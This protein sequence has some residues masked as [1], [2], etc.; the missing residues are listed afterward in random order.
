M[1]APLNVQ[2]S[3]RTLDEGPEL[4]LPTGEN[5]HLPLVPGFLDEEGFVKT[6]SM[7]EL[8]TAPKKSKKF[9]QTFGFV[10]FKVLDDEECEEGRKAMHNLFTEKFPSFE[11][12]NPS[13][14]WPTNKFGMIGQGRKGD[15]IVTQ[16]LVEL[17]THQNIH[18]CFAAVLEDADLL[19]GVDRVLMTRPKSKG[20]H[21]CHD[22]RQNLHLDIHI[23]DWFDPQRTTGK[24]NNLFFQ[25]K[26]K[27]FIS[28]NNWVHRDMGLTVQGILNLEVSYD[29][30]GGTKVVPGSHH[31]FDSFAN[32]LKACGEGHSSQH[33]FSP[34]CLLGLHCRSVPQR[35]GTL[36]V[37]DQRL[38]HSGSANQGPNWRYGIP[39]RMFRRSQLQQTPTRDLR[40]HAWALQNLGNIANELNLGE[41]ERRLLHLL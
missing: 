37:F 5:I 10:A 31:V 16:K 8:L 4:R 6:F 33:R 14:P 36:L 35:A 2:S 1:I 40:R 29:G 19:V 30:N 25:N 9:F 38:A 24:L 12:N 15:P 41:R 18:K 20:G 22:G 13:F 7:N 21:G 28:E 32:S 11:S 34:S 3:G 23:Q 26:T 17:R 27:D 39:I